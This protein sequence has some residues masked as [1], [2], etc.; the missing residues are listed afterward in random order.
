MAKNKC[1]CEKNK[2]GF[3]KPFPTKY[4]ELP[5]NHN[6][7]WTREEQWVLWAMY[8]KDKSSRWCADVLGRTVLSVE[9]MFFSM[10][11]RN[12]RLVCSNTGAEVCERVARKRDFFISRA[13]K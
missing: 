3:C 7:K 5:T 9:G 8:K 13:Y 10:V 11:Q 12:R 4:R 1:Q 6:K 2:A